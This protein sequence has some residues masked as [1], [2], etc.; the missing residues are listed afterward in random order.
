MRDKCM[1]AYRY[2]CLYEAKHEFILMSQ[3]NP[4]MFGPPDPHALL[5]CHF[6]LQ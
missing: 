6:P 2:I 1:Y 3:T 4:V 5:I